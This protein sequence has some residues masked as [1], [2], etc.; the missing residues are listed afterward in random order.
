MSDPKCVVFCGWKGSGK[1]TFS[2]FLV[3]DHKF[4][5]YAFADTLKDYCSQ[6]YHVP[7][8]LFDDVVHKDLRITD[9]DSQAYGLTPRDLCIK[10]GKEYRDKDPD[11]WIK[12][13]FKKMEVQAPPPRYVISDCRYPNELKQ[14]REHF[15]SNPN[16]CLVIWIH[17]WD[18]PPSTDPSEISLSKDDCDIVLDNTKL[19]RFRNL[20]EIITQFLK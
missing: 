15:D 5:R 4:T 9:P 18:S 12:E 7:R 14:L 16:N 13:V 17:R 1:D 6:T 11:Y 19:L 3:K 20:K 2:N 8:Y 10:V